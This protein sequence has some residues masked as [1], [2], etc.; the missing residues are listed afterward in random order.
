MEPNDLP[1]DIRWAAAF[2][3]DRFFLN[4]MG[5]GYPC[6]G[7]DPAPD[8]FFRFNVDLALAM[9]AIEKRYGADQVELMTQRLMLAMLQ[10]VEPETVAGKE[11]A[12]I[13]L[14]AT[15]VLYDLYRQKIETA[16][17]EKVTWIGEVA[18]VLPGVLFEVPNEILHPESNSDQSR[19]LGRLIV[20]ITEQ[21]VK[22][23]KKIETIFGLELGK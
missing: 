7:Y 18:F 23:A 21:Y 6:D 14:E 2:L 1:R 19:E 16:N 9:L 13:D 10:L 3:A 22:V 8:A 15:R 5:V 4:E 20:E 11:P 12:D 17:P